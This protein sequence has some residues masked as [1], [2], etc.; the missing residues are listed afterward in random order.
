MTD[1]D[2]TDE[3]L[4]VAI[5]QRLAR[6]GA[7]GPLDDLGHEVGLEDGALRAALQRLAAARHLVLDAAGE[8][9]LAHPFATRSFG[10]S[11]MGR[12]TLWWGGCAWDSFAIPHLVPD[13]PEVLVATRCP[14][15]SAPLAW[16]VSRDAPPDGPGIAHFAVPMAQAWD[17]VVHTC[18]QQQVYCGPQCV[19]A[20][21]AQHPDSPGD[22]FDLA[23]LWRLAAGWYDGRLSR[24]YRRREPAEAVEYFRAAGLRGRFWGLPD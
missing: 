5:Y 9:V 7:V 12:D 16:N 14:A 23:T 22:T 11:V 3:A 19:A 6:T 20:V 21:T 18:S 17:D 4:R 24:A 15:C 2:S 8:I 1:G 10:F 13:E